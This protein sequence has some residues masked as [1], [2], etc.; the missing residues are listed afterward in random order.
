MVSRR[1]ALRTGSTAL[2]AALAGCAG[3]DGS[4]TSSRTPAGGGSDAGDSAS[5]R[6]TPGEPTLTAETV[7]ASAVPPGATVAVVNDA[8]YELVAAAANADGR[9]D[10]LAGGPARDDDP[11]ALGAFD[12]L[13]FRGETYRP[14]ASYASFAQE[15]SLQYSV[16]P[17]DATEGEVASYANLSDAEREVADLLLAGETYDVG[18]HEEKPDAAT[19][20]DEHRYLR[21]GNETYRIRV[22][23]GDIMAHHMLRLDPADPGADA[24]VV[25]VA[26]DPVPSSVRATV[27]AAISNGSAAVSNPDELAAFLDAVEFVVTRHEVAALRTELD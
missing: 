26:D 15:A 2:V 6:T 13:R 3:S 17:A 5:T 14:V 8:L 20:F 16:E 24:R 10:L 19:V 9:V 25:S 11:L 18:H 4:G 23:V 22:V 27:T 12:Y 1:T 7:A 21:A